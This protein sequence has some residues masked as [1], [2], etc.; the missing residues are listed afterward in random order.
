M[1][2]KRA[3]SYAEDD[4]QRKGGYL[5]SVVNV[6]EDKWLYGNIKSYGD[7]TWIGL[8]DKAYEEHFEWTSGI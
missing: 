8:N 4:C 7:D 2:F 3:W 5:T 1:T 6:N